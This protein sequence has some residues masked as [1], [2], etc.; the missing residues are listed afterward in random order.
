MSLGLLGLVT[1]AAC[2]KNDNGVPTLTP[3]ETI[4]TS[5]VW[6]LYSL[7]VPKSNNPS[8]D[9][10]ITKPCSDSTLVAFDVYKVYQIADRSLNSCDSTI[11]PYD[12]G[13]WALSAAD[14]LTLN[15]GNRKFVWKIQVLNDSL[16]KATYRDSTAPTRNWLKTIT[17][18]K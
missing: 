1:F 7:T 6:K 12:R 11:V 3:K 8:E 18:K 2:K 5:K 16:V 9:S 4:L 14:S 13:T 15:G 10:S 17:F